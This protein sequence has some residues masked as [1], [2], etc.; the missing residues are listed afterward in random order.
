PPRPTTART[1]RPPGPSGAGRSRYG[2]R[3][4]PAPRRAVAVVPHRSPLKPPSVPEPVVAALSPVSG[5]VRFPARGGA[6]PAAASATP[7]PRDLA[8]LS[9]GEVARTEFRVRRILDP[10]QG[11]PT[12]RRHRDRRGSLIFLQQPRDPLLRAPALPHSHH[13]AH[14]TAHH[15]PAEG[16]RTH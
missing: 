13:R 2:P 8:C 7:A 10:G 15:G 6:D 9:R 11:Q 5:Q 1:P 14:E 16:V 3:T 12:R 4:G